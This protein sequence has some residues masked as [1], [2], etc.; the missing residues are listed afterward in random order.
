[1]SWEIVK[2]FHLQPP[3][4]KLPREDKVIE[5][6]DSIMKVVK[7]QQTLPEYLMTKYFSNRDKIVFTKNDFPYYTTP[8]II[9]CLLWIH[10]TVKILDTDISKVINSSIPDHISCKEYIYFENLGNNKS[11]QEIRHFHIFIRII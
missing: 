4:I 10:P 7:S 8:N 1:M 5:R 6:Y 3:K 11:I 2:S 9:H